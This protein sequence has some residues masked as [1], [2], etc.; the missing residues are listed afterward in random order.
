MNLFYTEH[1]AEVLRCRGQIQIKG[2][3]PRYL[4]VKINSNLR[5]W[6]IAI[7]NQYDIAVIRIADP[8][9]RAARGNRRIHT[10]GT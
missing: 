7:Y 9:I 5:A 1:P 4:P 8:E 10:L 3:I 6:N 2:I